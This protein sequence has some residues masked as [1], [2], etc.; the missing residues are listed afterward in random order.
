MKKFSR[1]EKF[2]LRR[3]IF[4]I[5]CITVFVTPLFILN[6][7]YCVNILEWDDISFPMLLFG[8]FCF[9]FVIS[10]IKDRIKEKLVQH[11]P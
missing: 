3:V 5:L 10:W 8:S 4:Y 11:N 1:K 9:M 2:I 6:E 7:L